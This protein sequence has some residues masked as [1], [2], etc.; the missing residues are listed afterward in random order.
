[1][2]SYLDDFLKEAEL[3]LQ[4]IEK[5]NPDGSME[6][7]DDYQEIL[8]LH[9]MLEEYEIP[10]AMFQ[11]FDGWVIHYPVMG[12]SPECACSCIQHCFSYGGFFD[13]IEISGLLSP[14]EAEEDA[15]L[16]WLTAEDVFGRIKAH[17]EAN[18]P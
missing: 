15:V 7:N 11:H 1:M 8:K 4:A 17:W 18:K 9:E 10:H 3:R 16:G 2:G 5:I 12:P 13:K 6:V 14:E